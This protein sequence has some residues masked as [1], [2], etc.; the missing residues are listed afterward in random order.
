MYACLTVED[1]G[2]DGVE[3]YLSDTL[4]VLSAEEN[5]PGNATRVLALE[6][7]GLGFAVLEAEDLAVASDV[8]LTLR[9]RKP[10]SIS[11]SKTSSWNIDFALAVRWPG[12][13]SVDPPRW[14][15]PCRTRPTGQT[16][17]HLQT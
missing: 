13:S 15:I 17:H 14:C 16:H 3:S 2:W 11:H 5:G 7:E 10:I 1:G 8:E 4:A 12:H 6:E 9:A